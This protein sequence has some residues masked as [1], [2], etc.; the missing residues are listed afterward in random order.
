MLLP[1]EDVSEPG[2]EEALWRAGR[3]SCSTSSTTGI[4]VC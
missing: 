3:N 1:G 2:L 4:P